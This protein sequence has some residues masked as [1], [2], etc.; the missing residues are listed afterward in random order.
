MTRSYIKELVVTLDIMIL[1]N[2]K[3][4]W[5]F[6]ISFFNFLLCFSHL[7]HNSWL[8][9]RVLHSWCQSLINW[10]FHLQLPWRPQQ[11]DQR[12][13]M[14]EWKNMNK[15]FTRFR[16]KFYMFE[17]MFKLYLASWMTCRLSFPLWWQSGNKREDKLLLLH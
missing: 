11:F 6:L 1:V 3:S 17:K 9:I 5:I 4:L 8:Q 12:V 2:N 10:C 13:W 15:Q 14:I 7:F 16:V